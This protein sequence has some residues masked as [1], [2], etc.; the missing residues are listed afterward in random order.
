MNR[1]TFAEAL[2]AFG[3]MPLV[4]SAPAHPPPLF[5]DSIGTTIVV[6]DLVYSDREPFPIEVY[7]VPAVGE[8]VRI[9][10]ETFAVKHVLHNYSDIEQPG[11]TVFIVRPGGLVRGQVPPPSVDELP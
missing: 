6:H 1:R 4:D 11:V 5:A 2:G 9:G 10:D 8:L 3:T 7:A